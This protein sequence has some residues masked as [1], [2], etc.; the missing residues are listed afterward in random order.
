[1]W[2]WILLGIMVVLAAVFALEGA[3]LIFAA[4]TFGVGFLLVFIPVNLLPLQLAFLPWVI[5]PKGLKSAGLVL[6]LALYAAY[7]FVP[8]YLAQQ[9]V[10][11]LAVK[12][13]EADIQLKTPPQGVRSFALH[14][15]SAATQD[16]CPEAC[17]ALIISGEADWVRVTYKNDA[18]HSF[19]PE[20]SDT[21]EGICIKVIQNT[22]LPADL[23]LTQSKI[24][25]SEVKAYFPNDPLL[26]VFE[27]TRIEAHAGS[28]PARAPIYR[29][30]SI[31]YHVM[32]SP[33]LL[34]PLLDG[35][36]SNG[37]DVMRSRSRSSDVTHLTALRAIG[38]AKS[39]VPEE[40][41]FSMTS[42]PLAVDRSMVRLALDSNAATFSKAENDVIARFVFHVRMYENIPAS[43]LDLVERII[44]DTRVRTHLDL[45]HVLRHE[46]EFRIRILPW[47]FDRFEQGRMEKNVLYYSV[48]NALRFVYEPDELTPYFER[49][50]RLLR[51]DDPVNSE[52]AALVGYFSEDPTAL[53][54]A[55]LKASKDDLK[56]AKSALCNAEPRWHDAMMPDLMAAF[57]RQ[58]E[59]DKLDLRKQGHMVEKIAYMGS[60]MG[61]LAEIE[62]VLRAKGFGDDV[63][64]RR[65]GRI[66][67]QRGAFKRSC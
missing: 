26:K 67:G 57:I 48:F 28:D 13:A 15:N 43:V 49:Y 11:A 62:P 42:T 64:W 1:M 31:R 61:Y 5:L 46:K 22:D 10:E 36:N 9:R 4:L 60:A 47:V 25:S 32:T 38:W 19:A 12:V 34:E 35:V 20:T 65:I 30:N 50:A 53:Y 8:S 41:P 58:M 17:K 33:T 59:G 40:E 55:V 2:Y 27:T 37:Y 54:R 16:L 66:E 7:L 29:K 44:K 52:F 45:H 6:G 18:V 14:Y 56:I 51:T 3:A 23:T 39:G 24:S 63:F 21:C